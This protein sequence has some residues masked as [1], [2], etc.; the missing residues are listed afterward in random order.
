MST[1]LK[2]HRARRKAFPKP[3][4]RNIRAKLKV[5]LLCSPDPQDVYIEI[6]KKEARSL[7]RRIERA[8][9][10]VDKP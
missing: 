2:N 4:L 7:V 3:L 5:G 9:R 8:L 6:H 1:D 10:I